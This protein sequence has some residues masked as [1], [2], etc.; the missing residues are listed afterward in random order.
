ML[1]VFTIILQRKYPVFRSR[2]GSLPDDLQNVVRTSRISRSDEFLNTPSNNH[3][4][5]NL[6]VETETKTLDTWGDGEQIKESLV[7]LFNKTK[8]QINGE[9]EMVVCP[10]DYNFEQDPNFS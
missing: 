6:I 10:K 9:G 5:K 4:I 7:N 2:T 8:E 3:E 1:E